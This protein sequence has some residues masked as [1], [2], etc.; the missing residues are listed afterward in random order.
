MTDIDAARAAK[1]EL[2][3]RFAGDP[4]VSGIGISGDAAHLV[5]KVNLVNA[6]EVPEDLPL[7]VFGFPVDV[8]E[9]GRIGAH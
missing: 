8:E 3:K 1:R 6:Q 2:V 5:I 4:R 7:K 9:V